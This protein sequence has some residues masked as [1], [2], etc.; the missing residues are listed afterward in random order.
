VDDSEPVRR[1][2]RRLFSALPRFKVV[3]EAED[4][5]QALEA[6]NKLSPDLV[7]LDIHM[8]RMNG[9][10]VLQA[11][12][13]QSSECRVIVFSQYG[14]KAYRD[15]CLELGACAFFEKVTGFDQF[16]CMLKEMQPRCPKPPR[17]GRNDSDDNLH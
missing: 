2:L 7:I 3:G 15:K 17:P 1:V 8:P 9:L 6:I 13:E 4:G 10:E 14:E 5:F 11:L 12:K 16:H